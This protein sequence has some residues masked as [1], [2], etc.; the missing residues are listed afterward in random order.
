[1]VGKVDLKARVVDLDEGRQAYLVVALLRLIE[2][3]CMINWMPRG[4]NMHILRH[5]CLLIVYEDE[6]LDLA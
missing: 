3:E 1:M 4:D 6:D 5:R 2:A